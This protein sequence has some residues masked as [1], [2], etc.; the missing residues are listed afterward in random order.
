MYYNFGINDYIYPVSS[1]QW[2]VWSSMI[3]RCYDGNQASNP[4]FMMYSDCIVHESW[5]LSST[6]GDWATVQKGFNEEG[7]KIDKDILFNGNKIYSPETCCFV[8]NEINMALTLRNND[9]G[10]LPLGVTH[11]RHT[12]KGEAFYVK[13]RRGDLPVV[14]K[15]F[16]DINEARMFYI[17]VKLNHIS[18][19]ADKYEEVLDE[20]VFLKLKNYEL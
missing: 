13:V 5:K 11:S 20:R 6:F 19:L 1:K 14:N 4:R 17:K 8:P 16:Y 3:R 7:S 12:K 18:Y 2:I 15:C 9:R 10:D